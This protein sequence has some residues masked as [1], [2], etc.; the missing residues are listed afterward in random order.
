VPVIGEAASRCEA[1]VCWS[2]PARACAWSRAAFATSRNHSGCSHWY[3]P[4]RGDP[5]HAARA[6]RARRGVVV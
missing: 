4:P 3:L 1:S 2:H 5:I 6:H